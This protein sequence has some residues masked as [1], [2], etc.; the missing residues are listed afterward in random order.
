MHNIVQAAILGSRYN[1]RELARRAGVS[2][3]TVTRIE[4]GDI[5]PT[6]GMATRILAAAGLQLPAH[7]EPLSD[8][9]ALKAARRILDTTDRDT[10]TPEMEETLIRWASPDGTPHPRQLA[11]EAAAAA[12]PPLRPGVITTTSDWG[13]LRI[14]SA[15]A[16]TRK[17]WAVSGAPAAGRIGAPAQDGPLILYVEEP[18]RV[19][20]IIGRPGSSAV[21]VILL[22]F[23]G[24]S[25]SG[26][27]N[28]EGV[29][30]ADP[31]QIILDCYGMPETGSLADELTRDWE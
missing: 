28:D 5:D 14:C 10:R 19:A 7:P 23:D 18:S 3:S 25:E 27:W 4:K 2:P 30:W 24:S 12:P 31:I 16:A 20:S 1:R 15:A 29:V 6:L 26:A 21:D 17:G 22:P 9:T 8:I 11:K 13:F